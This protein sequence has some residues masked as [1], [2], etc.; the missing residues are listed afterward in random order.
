MAE[1]NELYPHSTRREI[2][3]YPDPV[4]KQK[5]KPVEDFNEELK[6]LANDMLF[7]MYQAPGIGLAGPQIGVDKR[8]FVLDVDFN[9]SEKNNSDGNNVYDYS[10]T[11]P[12]VFINPVFKAVGKEKEKKPR[13]MFK[14]TRY[15]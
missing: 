10:E 9:R 12:K 3:I 11:K 1:I 15:L 5:A 13:G 2:I 6:T 4:L 7:T 8:I 14:S